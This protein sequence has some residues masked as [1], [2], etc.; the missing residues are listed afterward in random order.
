MLIEQFYVGADA[1]GLPGL[2]WKRKNKP[3]N[4]V[5]PNGKFN[6]T[7]INCTLKSLQ[8]AYAEVGAWVRGRE[9]GIGRA[10]QRRLVRRPGCACVVGSAWL[11]EGRRGWAR[12]E[13]L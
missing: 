10:G 9:G 7:W 1:W 11:G 13:R 5:D 3:I 2:P 6:S 8:E 4:R 12:K